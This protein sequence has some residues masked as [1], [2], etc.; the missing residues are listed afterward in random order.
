MIKDK[1]LDYL[2]RV[3]HS[4]LIQYEFRTIGTSARPESGVGEHQTGEGSLYNDCAERLGS[5]SMR[6]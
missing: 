1:F 2:K 5:A 4:L 6:I 3:L